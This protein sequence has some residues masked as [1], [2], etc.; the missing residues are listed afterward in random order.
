MMIL[1]LPHGSVAGRLIAEAVDHGWPPGSDIHT[2]LERNF[3]WGWEMIPDEADLYV[4]SFGEHIVNRLLISGNRIPTLE[5]MVQWARATFPQS[6]VYV[7]PPD[8]FDLL[9]ALSFLREEEFWSLTS[10]A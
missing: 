6:S 10:K 9:D 7:T 3:E 1:R 4:G 8:R 2:M 5:A